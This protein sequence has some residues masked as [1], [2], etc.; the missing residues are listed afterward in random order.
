MTQMQRSGRWPLLLRLTVVPLALTLLTGCFGVGTVVSAATSAA[1]SG[2]L[3][4]GGDG[5]E[6]CDSPEHMSD[7]LN[8]LRG[9]SP[10]F[11]GWGGLIGGIET[12]KEHCRR[13]PDLRPV[14]GDCVSIGYGYTACPA[15]ADGNMV[16]TWGRGGLS[17]GL[18]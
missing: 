7:Y 8:Q 11:L 16:W 1:M 12:A 14:A 13:Y 5:T 4:A 6:A 17:T 3:S 9:A 2:A 10:V 15:T 18:N